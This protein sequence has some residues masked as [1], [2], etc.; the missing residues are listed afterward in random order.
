MIQMTFMEDILKFAENMNEKEREE[1]LSMAVQI[2]REE[3]EFEL[4]KIVY[5]SDYR[6]Q[7]DKKRVDATIDRT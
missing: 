3:D 7:L 6:K 2:D 1:F 4:R 5:L